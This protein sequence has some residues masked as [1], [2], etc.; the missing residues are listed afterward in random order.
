ME[1]LLW[2]DELKGPE[3]VVPH[4]E[5]HQII[6]AAQQF[7]YREGIS[8]IKKHINSLVKS[9]TKDEYTNILK[10]I[11]DLMVHAKHKNSSEKEALTQAL[12]KVYVF[13]GGKDIKGAKDRAKMIEKRI[14]H[15]KELQQDVLKRKL[16][17]QIRVVKKGSDQILLAQLE[18]E[19]K[20][21]YGK[22]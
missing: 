6:V 11:E 3:P 10:G 7:A 5:L 9:K 14:Q 4:Q 19:F 17:R 13:T 16:L 22:N 2:L 8:N 20:E 15:Y 1:F 21:K 12:Y 18:Q